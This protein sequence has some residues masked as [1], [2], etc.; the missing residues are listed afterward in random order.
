ME[1]AKG[2]STN[3]YDILGGYE[4]WPKL[5]KYMRQVMMMMMERERERKIMK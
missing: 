2:H 4:F 5:D 1:M 3:D